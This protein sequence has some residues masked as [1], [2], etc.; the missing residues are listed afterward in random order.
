MQ[1]TPRARRVEFN[2]P[3][4]VARMFSKI[5]AV[6]LDCRRAAQPVLFAFGPAEVALDLAWLHSHFGDMHLTM[7]AHVLGELVWDRR[8]T[9]AVRP[10]R[11]GRP[12]KAP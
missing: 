10:A 12:R 2:W 7:R 9:T 4:K 1:V 11:R 5:V 6:L 3:E 8:M